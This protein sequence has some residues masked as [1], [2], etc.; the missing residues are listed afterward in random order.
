MI[1]QVLLLRIIFLDKYSGPFIHRKILEL[2][3]MEDM[4]ASLSKAR[5]GGF[6]LTSPQDEIEIHDLADRG[7]SEFLAAIEDLRKEFA[8]SVSGAFLPF[9]SS[10]VAPFAHR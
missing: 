5:S 2:A 6:I 8:I 1:P 10:C 4:K 9:S 7:T 3:P